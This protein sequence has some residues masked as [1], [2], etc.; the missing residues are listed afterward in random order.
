VRGQSVFKP[1]T[2]IGVASH[3]RSHRMSSIKPVWR[4]SQPS[5]RVNNLSFVTT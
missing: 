4:I 2:G 1:D 5:G 3:T